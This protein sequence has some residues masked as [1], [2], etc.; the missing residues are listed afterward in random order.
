MKKLLILIIGLLI[1][2][3]QS[4][5][6]PTQIKSDNIALLTQKGYFNSTKPSYYS[7]P[8]DEIKKTLTLHTKY[9]NSYDLEKLKNLYSEKYISSDGLNRDIYFELVQKTWESYPDI[10]YKMEVKNI[11]ITD[12][13][14]VVQIR[15]TATATTNGQSKIVTDKGSLASLSDTVYYLER[16]NNQWLVTSDNILFEKTN[17][18]YGS[19]KE[20]D[21]ILTAPIQVQT[22]TQYT[23]SL[24]ITQPKDSFIIASIGHENITYP[25]SIAEE[26][27][28]KLPEDGILERV[29]T[30]NDKNLNEYAVASFGITK[31]EIRNGKE[32]KIFVTGLG[33]MMNRV[34]VIPY[35]K[36]VKL[37]AKTEVKVSQNDKNEQT[38]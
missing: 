6:E 26:V 13:L 28:R 16:V 34:N 14:A 3:L 9:S 36:D 30:A 2:N 18:M 15:E 32:I 10:K 5:A 25:Q 38:K 37:D 29:T 27:F 24:K 17:L 21:A 23:T 31:A 8:C 7:N 4:N 22:N 1:T 12:N 33:F 35:K 11:E 20:L 19:A